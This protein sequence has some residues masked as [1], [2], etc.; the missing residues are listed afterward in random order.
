MYFSERVT[1][2]KPLL[3]GTDADGFQIVT[4]W[5]ER[6]VWADRKSPT[7][8]EFYAA[9]QVGI[10]LTDTFVVHEEDYQDETQLIWHGDTYSIVRAYER[11]SVVELSCHTKDV[12]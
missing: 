4:E 5:S 9:N 12:D 6:T 2:K 7:R 1:L 3:Y 11:G 10:D 8:S